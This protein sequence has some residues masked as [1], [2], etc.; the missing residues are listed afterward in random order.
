ML[1]V[2]F[3]KKLFISLDLKFG[4]GDFFWWIINPCELFVFGFHSFVAGIVYAISS[5]EQYF[6]FYII[7]THSNNVLTL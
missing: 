3:L 1:W 2:V 6:C 4:C 7:G 5:C